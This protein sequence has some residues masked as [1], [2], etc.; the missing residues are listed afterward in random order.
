MN[1]IRACVLVLLVYT[2]VSP[3]F[4]QQKVP[5]NNGIP[6]APS[7]IVAQPLP[8]GPVTYKTAEG[9]DIR[10]VVVARGLA[11]PWSLA[12]LPDPST[13]LAAGAMLVTERPGRLR[14][15]RNGVLDPQPVAGVP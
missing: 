7:G 1:V 11:T 8:D 5:I 14:V 2:V 12:F 13:T 15:I 9:Q 3:L 10:V 4:A 6:V